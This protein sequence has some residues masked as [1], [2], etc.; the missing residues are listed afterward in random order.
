MPGNLY[1]DQSTPWQGVYFFTNTVK[2]GTVSLTHCCIV[3]LEVG[4]IIAINY[5]NM[6]TLLLLKKKGYKNWDPKFW[7]SYHYNS[8]GQTASNWN[9]QKLLKSE[10]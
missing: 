3:I 8:V 7:L 5:V 6:K 1:C 9:L 2:V 10:L 4:I